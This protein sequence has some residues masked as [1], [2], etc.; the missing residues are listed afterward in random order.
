MQ[1]SRS[2]PECE[3]PAPCV[4]P[5]PHREVQTADGSRN[6]RAPERRGPHACSHPPLCL[7]KASG[8]GRRGPKRSC[9]SAS[10]IGLRLL[11]IIRA[12]TV[13]TSLLWSLAKLAVSTAKLQRRKST[14]Q[15]NEPGSCPKTQDVTGLDET[16]L[17]PHQSCRPRRARRQTPPNPLRGSLTAGLPA[18][19]RLRAVEN[20]SCCRN[21]S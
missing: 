18:L 1:V 13:V 16:G 17:C 9:P 20:P 19:A 14:K 7:T 8:G 12:V 6:C 10:P 11:K 2:L 21:A 5:W 4:S 15:R 3:P